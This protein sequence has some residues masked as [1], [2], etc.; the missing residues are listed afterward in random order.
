M[1]EYP[2]SVKA[3]VL[4]A[5]LAMATALA[6]WTARAEESIEIVGA[7][8]QVGVPEKVSGR[9][10]VREVG[11]LSRSLEIIFTD[12]A[13][14]EQILSFDEDLTQQLHVLAIDS[15]LTTLV[16]EHVKQAEPDGALRATVNFPSPGVY[17][18]YADAHPTD[19]GQQ[20]LRFDVAVPEGTASGAPRSVPGTA[21]AVAF[22]GPYRVEVDTSKMTAMEESPVTIAIT[23]EGK[24][25]TDL[26]P[27]LGVAAH[28][29]FIR[30]DDLAYVHVHPTIRTNAA[31]HDHGTAQMAVQEPG[32]HQH[33]IGAAPEATGHDHAAEPTGPVSPNIALEVTAP[34]PGPYVLFLQFVGDGQVRT[35][36]LA[37]DVAINH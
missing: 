6:T 19:L 7:F 10:V 13:T 30:M 14:G 35:V 16:H 1:G 33:D 29:V 8:A 26:G 28:A 27:Y 23:K 18:I 9:M 31:A 21:V 34:G 36:S 32:A 37:L 24:P 22:D 15:T 3:A 11:P 25:A 17:H 2:V 20:V 12:A 5:S 4:F